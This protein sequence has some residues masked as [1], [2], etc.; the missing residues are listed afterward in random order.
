MWARL[1]T[2]RSPNADPCVAD[3][4]I[5]HLRIV[6]HDIQSQSLHRQPAD[7]GQQSVRSDYAIMLRGHQGHTRIDEFLLRIEDVER[8]SLPAPPRG[9]H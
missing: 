3:L 1:S 7:R 4:L 8:G 2:V 5:V 6:D 9:R